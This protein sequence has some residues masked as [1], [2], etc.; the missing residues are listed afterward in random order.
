M[1]SAAVLLTFALQF[2]VCLEIAWNAIKDKFTKNPT[3]Y[4]YVTRTVLVIL[5]ISVAI[6]VPKIE[7]LISLISAF[8]FSVLGLLM[9]VLIETIVF[10]EGNFGLCDWKTYKNIIIAFF[11]LICFI[12]GTQIALDDIYREYFPFTS[13]NN[14]TALI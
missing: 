14:V 2:F 6:A 11:S 5:A 12:F 8:C 10:W 4:N 1:I 3:F 13:D 9:P 7:P